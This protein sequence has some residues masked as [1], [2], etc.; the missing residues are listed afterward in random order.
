MISVDEA[1]DTFR[2]RLE[3]SKTEQADASRRQRDVRKCIAAE[4]DIEDDFLTGSYARHTKTKPLKDVDIFF[5]LGSED[6]HWRDKP[7]IEVLREFETVLAEQYGDDETELGRRCVTVE[8]DKKN[9][10]T[11][12]DGKVLS[13]DAVPAIK[14]GNDFEIPDRVLDR[15]IKTNPKA[16]AD[17]AVTKNKA[18]NQRWKPL[19]KML[20]RWNRSAGKPIKPAFLIEVMA[21]DLIQGPLTTDSEEIQ[22]FFAA[23]RTAVTQ[24]WPDPAGLGPPVSDQMDAAQRAIAVPALRDA[25]VRASR[26]RRLDASGSTGDALA[27][28]R[29]I[30]GKYFPTR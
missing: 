14:V 23:A 28:W 22:R 29:E 19:V 18:L 24:D 16:H 4:F 12:E 27:L 8:F 21:M 25:E 7:P 6:R 17:A 5:C 13:V 11:D 10:T 26:A 15:W 30:M 2:R 9:P 1:F 3:L 20:K